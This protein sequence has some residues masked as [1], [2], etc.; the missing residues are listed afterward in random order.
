M[1]TT[2]HLN[3]VRQRILSR[4]GMHVPFPCVRVTERQFLAHDPFLLLMPEGCFC[5]RFWVHIGGLQSNQDM[6]ATPAVL[7]CS[8]TD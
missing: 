6:A 3:F 4:S 1:S 5:A 8:P 7:V 2:R